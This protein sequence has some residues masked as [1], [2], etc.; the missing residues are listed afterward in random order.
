MLTTDDRIN[1]FNQSRTD[2][3]TNLM[4]NHFLD[5]NGADFKDTT[6]F[7]SQTGKLRRKVNIHVIQYNKFY[8][9]THS[10]VYM[11]IYI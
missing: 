2:S 7:F 4:D 5:Q 9:A 8:A 6:K 1:S 10:S 3:N 11:L